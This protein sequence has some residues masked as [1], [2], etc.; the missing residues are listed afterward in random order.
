M[1]RDQEEA[2]LPTE[3][4]ASPEH[5]PPPPHSAPTRHDA[6]TPY[7]PSEREH[8]PSKP[9]PQPSDP[10]PAPPH[11]R[12][13]T[14]RQALRIGTLALGASALVAGGLVAWDAFQ[15]AT[16]PFA[17]VRTRWLAQLTGA[18]TDDDAA[19]RLLD[20]LGPDGRW[21][22][23]SLTSRERTVGLRI[24]YE[25]LREL[26]R[27]YATPGSRYA[28]DPEVRDVLLAGLDRLHEDYA[29]HTGRSGNW[30]DRQVGIPLQL[31]ATSMLLYDDLGEDRLRR[32]M[33]T[34]HEQTPA[35]AY[36]AAN[37]AWTGRVVVER[38]L[39]LDDED[40]LTAGLRGMAPA[41]RPTAS[42]DGIHADGSFLQH[43]VHP[44][45]GGY[46][47]S[48][49]TS[50]ATVLALL[51]DT[52]WHLPGPAL[53]D[54]LRWVDDGL[55]PWLH[56]G[57]VL[58]P[59]RGRNIAR[60]SVG[61]RDAGRAAASALRLLASAADGERA[62]RWTRL[63]AYA[64]PDPADG[65]TPLAPPE[66]TRVFPAM[67]RVVHRRPAFT[68][69]LAMSSARIA[70][71]ESIGAENLHG[72]Y[73]GSGA[74]YLYDAA[75]T[76]YDDD[77]WPTVDARRIPGTTTASGTPG[78]SAGAGF[79]GT[80]HWA[81]G[82]ALGSRAAVGMAFR[83]PAAPGMAEVSGF[84]SWFL[85]DDEIVALGTGIASASGRPVET[86][87]DNRRLVDPA[88]Q[89]LVVD[90]RTVPHAVGPG[91][92][93]PTVAD[94]ARWA[95][96]SGATPGTG[97]GYVFR[98]GQ[99]LRLLRE[100]RT[101]RWADINRSAPHR[102][103]TV[104]ANSFAT[105]WLEHG[106]DPAD[107]RYGYTI[108]PGAT[109]QEVASYAAAPRTEVLANSRAVQAVRRDDTV[110]LNVWQA[111]APETGGVRCDRPAAVLVVQEGTRLTVAVADPTQRLERPLRITLAR[112]AAR[113]TG[114]H[115]RVTVE[116]L[117][118]DI[119]L[120]VD[121][122]GARGATVTAAFGL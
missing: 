99:R 121:L 76:P 63:A 2:D 65:V 32:W 98:D 61:D 22:D 111:E 69:A 35:P 90:G 34:V 24:R 55:V 108:L 15:D 81:G 54:L 119:A 59:V 103:P 66:G 97:I 23:L 18:A 102:D 105:L 7:P 21:P 50:A 14:R 117:E 46:G 53:D 94:G 13:V 114:A 19:G 51:H 11:T 100:R 64:S 71:Y 27:A 26:A 37:R 25:R 10:S 86:V 29:A 84:T 72:W 36:T 4:D 17:A 82:A 85:L 67:D 12:P 38:A 30:W 20:Q 70:T 113:L 88:A 73:T 3:H 5:A 78:D 106:T 58:A 107:G 8:P 60:R 80:S 47:L 56:A 89:R 45:S 77:Y 116:R 43:D 87:V 48:L 122:A 96:L 1:T 109:P 28:Q 41:F 91:T 83:H 112:T 68:V 95:H 115:E 52:P 75:G 33:A 92:P 42:G 79:R 93:A 31:T 118:P 120:V 16:H 57:A 101:G 74:Y 104:R 110:A 40:A 44:Y 9:P 39:L 49:L 6:P 62:A